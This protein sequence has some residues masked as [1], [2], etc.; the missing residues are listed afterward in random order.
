[1]KKKNILVKILATAALLVSNLTAFSQGSWEY[2]YTGT[3][4][5]VATKKVV[6]IGTFTP[7]SGTNLDIIDTLISGSSYNIYATNFTNNSNLSGLFTARLNS[8]GDYSPQGQGMSVG[9]LVNGLSS[10]KGNSSGVTARA[11]GG[12]FSTSLSNLVVNNTSGAR[13]EVAGCVASLNGTVSAAGYPSN[14]VFAGLYAIDG[15]KSNLN[16]WAGYFDGNVCVLGTIRTTEVKIKVSPWAD[17]VFADSYKLTSLQELEKY[18]KLNRHLPG[19]PKEEEV[20]KDGVS[21]GEMNVKLLQK[22]EELTLYIIE[23]DKRLTELESKL[24]N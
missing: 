13:Y 21:L 6:G 18:I 24:K 1:M 9:G 2:G 4:S 8:C 7:R 15:I 3:P 22:V 5:I 19:I 20:N 16:T 17:F 14:K 11:V 12:Y 10:L 23:Q